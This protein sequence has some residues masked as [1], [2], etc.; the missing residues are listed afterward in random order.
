LSSIFSIKSN[1]IVNRLL[2]FVYK[3]FLNRRGTYLL[4]MD[5]NSI[6]KWAIG[7]SLLY[8]HIIVIISQPRNFILALYIIFLKTIIV[9]ANLGWSWSLMSIWY[10][11]NHWQIATPINIIIKFLYFGYQVSYK[12]STLLFRICIYIAS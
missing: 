5:I 6:T 8:R 3:D 1:Y 10:N 9:L 4:Q 11:H 2:C 12:N 7:L